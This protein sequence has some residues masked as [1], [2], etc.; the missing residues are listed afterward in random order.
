MENPVV[1]NQDLRIFVAEKSEADTLAKRA[2]GELGYKIAE[3]QEKAEY[4]ALNDLPSSFDINDYRKELKAALELGQKIVLLACKQLTFFY[5]NDPGKDDGKSQKPYVTKLKLNSLTL[6]KGGKILFEAE[7][8]NPAGIHSDICPKILS[9]SILETIFPDDWT[10][11]EEDAPPTSKMKMK[12]S[13][14]Y[15]YWKGLWY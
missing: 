2:L 8:G 3:E 13:K 15:V 7:I 12:K 14:K 6:D 5:F 10:K 9:H 4:L 11:C 1:S